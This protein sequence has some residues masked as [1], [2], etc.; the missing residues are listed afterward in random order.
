MNWAAAATVELHSWKSA[1]P[2]PP[3]L[4]SVQPHLGYAAPKHFVAYDHDSAVVEPGL[5]LPQPSQTYAGE[6]YTHFS[7]LINYTEIQT[8]CEK[9]YFLTIALQ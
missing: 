5:K 2:P 4:P 1:S 8:I 6:K 3:L 9:I 7:P